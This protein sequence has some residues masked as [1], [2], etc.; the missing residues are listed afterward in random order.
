MP[1]ANP[2][3][4]DLSKHFRRKE[5]KG[6]KI[7]CKYCHG[8]IDPTPAK[9]INERRKRHLVECKKYDYDE[10]ITAALRDYAALQTCP[11]YDDDGN[12]LSKTIQTL[13]VLM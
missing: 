6:P 10:S 13:I 11:L 12:G 7:M 1:P 2:A 8:E 9:G 4:V 5:R 3:P